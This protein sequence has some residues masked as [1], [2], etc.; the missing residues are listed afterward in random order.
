MRAYRRRSSAFIV[1]HSGTHD[2]RSES[3]RSSPGLSADASSTTSS[4]TDTPTLAADYAQQ[5]PVRVIGLV[6]GV[7]EAMSDTFTGWVR[8]FTEIDGCSRGAAVLNAERLGEHD[9]KSVPKRSTNKREFDSR[10]ASGVLDQRVATRQAPVAGRACSRSDWR[11]RAW[12][13]PAP[14]LPHHA[15]QFDQRRVTN[16]RPRSL[17]SRVHWFERLPERPTPRRSNVDKCLVDEPELGYRRLDGRPVRAI[18]VGGRC[19]AS[20]Y[21]AASPWTIDPPRAERGAAGIVECGIGD[22]AAGPMPRFADGRC[23]WSDGQSGVSAATIEATGEGRNAS[24]NDR[25]AALE[26]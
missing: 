1:D 20:W 26:P 4:R 9:V 10:R 7:P 23:G 3:T 19:G 16:A 15:Y 22:V 25:M 2:G 12:P 13:S 17:R 18:A 6:L 14:N 5:I 11:I 21:R 24:M 8:E